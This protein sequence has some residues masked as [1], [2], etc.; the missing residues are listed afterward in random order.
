V[1]YLVIF[2]A[3]FLC[4][5]LELFWTRILNLKAW[6]HVVYTVIPFAI[7]GYG[8]GANIQLIVS[9]QIARW[10]VKRVL[11]GLLVLLSV[12]VAASTC[13]IVRL[14]IKVE[15]L[16]N[17]FTS[18]DA[19]GMLLVAYTL[20]MLP[21]IV[22]GF[23]VVYLFATNPRATHK[24][25]CVDLVGAALG[26]GLFFVLIGNW[27]VVH[28]LCALS[29]LALGLGAW[30]FM[31]GFRR[32][33][34][35]GLTFVLFLALVRLPEPV[36]YVVDPQKGWEWVPGNFQPKDYKLVSA[37]WH[38]L[39]RTDIY[40]MTDPVARAAM[41]RRSPGTFQINV[42]PT[43]ELAYFSTN[44]LGGT[45]AFRF[46]DVTK[47]GPYQVKIFSQSLE[48]PYLLVK[49]PRVMI[50]GVGGG[51]DIFMAR[52]HGAR[53]IVGAEINPGIV[54]A[55][56]RGGEAYE[57][58][59]RIYDA[60]KITAID[61]R[62]LV[63]TSL[64]NSYDLIILNGVDTFSGLSSGAYAYAESYLY[65]KNA[66]KDYLAILNDKGIIN[67][68]RWLFIPPRET[69]RL[70]AI[71]LE[72][73]KETGVQK[74][75][76]HIL[77]GN[78]G[79]FSMTLIK[80]TPFTVP[81]IQKVVKYFHNFNAQLIYPSAFD[82]K[83]T[84]HPFKFFDLYA[85]TFKENK[86][87][88][89]ADLYFY[90]I[91]VITDNNP[92][93]Y[94]YYKFH[95]K[96]LLWPQA[97]HHTGTIIFWTQFLVL[98]QALVFIVLFI[99]L[100]LVHSEETDIRN[101][102]RT[103]LVPLATYFACL[104]L[105]YMFIEL[106]Y[107]QRFVLL[108]GSPIYSI[109]VVL[110]GLLFWTGIGSFL[111]PRFRALFRDND[112]D[113]VA[114]AAAGIVVLLL[115]MIALGDQ[116]QDLA[117]AWPFAFRALLVGLWLAPAGI[118]LGFFFPLGLRVAGGFGQAAVAWGWGIN[119][120]FSVLGSMLA[121]IVAQFTGFNTVLLMAGIVYLLAVLAFRRIQV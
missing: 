59:G 44:F 103:N 83:I 121:I 100:P 52:S 15:F 40:Q 105:G 117:M 21:F 13:L 110:A 111:M 5:L 89:F 64:K 35:V 56:S 14:P 48:A 32:W 82:R 54:R 43:P 6:N 119:C 10:P 12:L 97:T 76:E 80:K 57:Y 99:V 23:L 81:E 98:L 53:E 79:G 16:L 47:A 63:K 95:W 69:L 1:N 108:L 87:W 90:D 107:M 33:V 93:F 68:N 37:R 3:S 66:L 101:I 18:L 4:I 60:A 38:A 112:R 120:G 115:A 36:D 49:D 62:H 85:D 20:F 102:P 75:W 77:I 28:S 96:D 17:V 27:A 109:S 31:S 29:A 92:F 84:N 34:G 39:G 22:I 86:Q 8:I 94:K 71:A 25:Y 67:F 106:P 88:A 50:I 61:G 118:L 65:T 74:P 26:A 30:L 51:R 46:A 42:I 78:L 70:M 104:G 116:A 73:L 9:R 91:S 2:V 41:M 19:A 45:P 11:G 55:M 72:A 113:T 58:S 114:C 24:L 7:L